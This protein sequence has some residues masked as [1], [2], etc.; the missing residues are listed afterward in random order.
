M[1]IMSS[2]TVVEPAS[3]D[4]VLGLQG[5]STHRFSLSDVAAL[6]SVVSIVSFGAVGDGTTD[7]TTVIQDAMDSGA[8]SLYVP[9]GTYLTG[10]I[11]IPTTLKEL[12]G[13]GTLKA[14]GVFTAFTAWLRAD[15]FDTL[16]IHGL[17]FSAGPAYTTNGLLNLVSG[18][19]WRVQDCTFSGGRFSVQ[20][21]G[22]T[23]SWIV[24]NS[25]S[26]YDQSAISAEVGV[27]SQLKIIGNVCSEPAAIGSIIIIGGDG[28]GNN[29]C[30]IIG[31]SVYGGAVFGIHMHDMSRGRISHNTTRETTLEGITVGGTSLWTEVAN[32]TC[33]WESAGSDV[34][35]SCGGDDGTHKCER[36]TVRNNV[37]VRASKGGILIADFSNDCVVQANHILDCNRSN[38]ASAPAGVQLSNTLRTTVLANVATNVGGGHMTYVVAED[39][40][41]NTSYIAGNYGRLMATGQVLT[42]GG[43]S[44]SIN[45]VALP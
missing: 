27:N 4:T 18:S 35:I 1:P 24:N 40:T 43:S 23:D 29:D 37:V 31:N 38:G 36:L 19:A 11:T 9:A 45:N 10:Q 41:T 25:C 6:S 39:G 44:V 20:I 3:T 7:N 15:T 21:E 22:S 33:Y 16:F 12:W 42:V 32:N 34:A 17:T 8:A 2:Y 13:P 5:G 30:D 28:T 26:G 14:N